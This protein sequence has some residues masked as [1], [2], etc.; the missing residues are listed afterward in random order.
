MKQVNRSVLALA[1]L[2]PLAIS[3][4]SLTNNLGI[5]EFRIHETV[6]E[7]HI[8]GLDSARVEVAKLSLKRS[9]IGRNLA[10]EVRG[11]KAWHESRGFAP[12]HLPLPSRKDR[13]ELNAFLLDAHVSSILQKWGIAV[14]SQLRPQAA[15]GPSH[16]CTFAE[17]AAAMGTSCCE[18]PAP[19][20]G[21]V[22]QL[23]CIGDR[24]NYGFVDRICTR[25]MDANNPCGSAGPNGCSVCWIASRTNHC[26]T[27]VDT[28]NP[29]RC[30]YEFR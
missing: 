6:D 1:A 25:P 15:V 3:Q 7:L 16:T 20:S 24:D 13:G 27:A 19:L 11:Q 4:T 5:A 21:A 23:V 22:E 14:G 26:F 30:V 2:L 10:V 17:S 8:S 18:M 12:L 29:D 28:N 9:G